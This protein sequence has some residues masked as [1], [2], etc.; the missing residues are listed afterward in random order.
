[1]EIETFLA[2]HK[3]IEILLN[4]VCSIQLMKTLSENQCSS[5]S[6]WIHIINQINYQNVTG[7]ELFLRYLYGRE[8]HLYNSRF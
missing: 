6:N 2:I 5:L 1:M 3:I 4:K 8:D 7:E